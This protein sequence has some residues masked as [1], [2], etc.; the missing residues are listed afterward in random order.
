MRATAPLPP[1]PEPAAS[2][3]ALPCT[4]RFGALDSGCVP[5]SFIEHVRYTVLIKSKQQTQVPFLAVTQVPIV[6]ALR[7][8][9]GRRK[10]LVRSDRK[11][12]AFREWTSCNC[13]PLSPRETAS[14][15]FA[16]A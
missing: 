7:G 1:V 5:A 13:A 15:R 10:T 16:I 8:G 3:E 11:A 12:R 4:S 2:K 6:E 14:P 9:V